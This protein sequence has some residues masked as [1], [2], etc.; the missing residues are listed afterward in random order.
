VPATF[1]IQAALK[2]THKVSSNA[3][4]VFRAQLVALFNTQAAGDPPEFQAHIPSICLEQAVI[5]YPAQ[6]A[7]FT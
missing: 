1:A 6:F 5:T 4:P 7:A 3:V 2:A